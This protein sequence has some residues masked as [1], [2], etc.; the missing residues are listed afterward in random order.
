VITISEAPE[1][2]M[3]NTGRNSTRRPRR[4]HFADLNNWQGIKTGLAVKTLDFRDWREPV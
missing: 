3:R 2:E 4:R 1:E